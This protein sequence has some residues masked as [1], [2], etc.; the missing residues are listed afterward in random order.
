MPFPVR[1][2]VFSSLS[3][4]YWPYMKPISLPPTPTSPAGTS[5]SGPIYFWS[6]VMNARQNLMISWS[7]FPFGEKSDPP[8]PPPIGRVV[9]EFL[10]ICSKPRNLKVPRV[11]EGW[12]LSPPLYGPM[13]L[14][15]CTLYPRFTWMLWSSS[16]H[17]TLNV[18]TLSGS[19]MRSRILFLRY[20][21]F[22]LTVSMTDAMISPAAWMNSGWAGFFLSSSAINFA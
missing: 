6:S 21:G 13:A 20:R 15:N 3:L 7:L 22:E 9:R 14:L 5:V 16:S 10:K 11:T 17:S 18:M 12:N 1:T 8:F 19:V 2:P 4:L